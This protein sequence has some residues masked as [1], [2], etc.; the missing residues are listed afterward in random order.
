[1]T[2]TAEASILKAE[3]IKKSYKTRDVI[4]GVSLEIAAGESVG[5]LGPNGAGKTTT[6][7]MIVGLVRPNSG[8]ITLDGQDITKLPMH[9]RARLGVGYLPQEASVFRKL[10]VKENI[11]AILQSRNDLT[12][13]YSESIL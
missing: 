11:V 2:V 1:M 8:Q 5:L 3:N 10:T 4:K 7:Y 13:A 9:A 6:F 12:R